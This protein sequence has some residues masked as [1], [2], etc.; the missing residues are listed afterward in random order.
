MATSATP[1]A[2]M[3]VDESASQ[4]ADIGRLLSVGPWR[5]VAETGYGVQAIS[6][7]QERT[8]A[9]AVVAVEEPLNRAI[10]TIES[11][12]AAAPELAIIAYSS[13]DSV[14]VVRRAMRAGAR[15][16]LTQP[17]KSE[18]LGRA[19]AEAIEGNREQPRGEER[20]APGAGTVITVVGAKGGIGKSTIAVNLATAIARQEKDS[21]LLID[22]DTRFGDVA[23]M[24]D[25]E[26][27]YVTADIAANV[28]TLNREGFRSALTE[29][30]SGVFILPSVKNPAEWRTMTP[31][32]L[33]Q[34]VQMAARLFDYVIIDTPGVYGEN[35]AAAIEVASQ[36]LLVTTVDITS[37]KDT[38]FVLE[39]LERTG[40]PK[41]RVL[42]T[43]N[44]ANG[45]NSVHAEDVSRVLHKDVYWELP[46]DPAVSVGLQSGTPVVV[47]RPRSAVAKSFSE[48]AARLT[49]VSAADQ[50]KQSLIRRILPGREGAGS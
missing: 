27:K 3:I 18:A 4:R 1:S 23:M 28:G 45:S 8:P 46:H 19:L 43:L 41:D 20:A 35:V 29:H 2:V 11:I 31:E 50:G 16:F 49:G 15:D 33:R 25:V 10:Q 7:V 13:H 48:M 30:E 26:P 14:D 12:H 6:L 37:V 36:V 32:Q 21:V 40:Y 42:L 34:L 24:M 22:M 17:L 47:A 38:T 9:I 44:H 39:I 5:L